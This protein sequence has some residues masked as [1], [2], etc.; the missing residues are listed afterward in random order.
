LTTTPSAMI[1]LTQFREGSSRLF[2]AGHSS[3]IKN[4]IPDSR[5]IHSGYPELAFRAES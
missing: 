5:I 1:G 4:D 2:D 3:G